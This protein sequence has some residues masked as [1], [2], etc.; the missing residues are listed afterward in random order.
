RRYDMSMERAAAEIEPVR[1]IA[2]S[3]SALPGPI[4]TTAPSR[5]RTLGCSSRGTIET[6][7]QKRIVR[8]LLYRGLSHPVRDGIVSPRGYADSPPRRCPVQVLLEP[9]LRD[10]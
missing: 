10:H 1:A 7:S 9:L 3:K 5:I 4:A 2:S 8:I 6:V